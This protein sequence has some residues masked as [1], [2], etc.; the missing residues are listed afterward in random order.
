MVLREFASATCLLNFAP[1]SDPLTVHDF[2]MFFPQVTIGRQDLKSKMAKDCP[3][4]PSIGSKLHS[5]VQGMQI[6]ASCDLPFLRA[7][8]SVSERKA[9]SIVGYD[10]LLMFRNFGNI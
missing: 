9:V 5:T 2:S 1:L 8:A 3:D 10:G 7:V 4:S 6:F